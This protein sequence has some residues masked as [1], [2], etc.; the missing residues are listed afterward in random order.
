MRP[1]AFGVEDDDLPPKVMLI[2]VPRQVVAQNPIAILTQL[3]LSA[4]CRGDNV[5]SQSTQFIQSRPT[6]ARVTPSMKRTKRCHL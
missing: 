5:R 2:L 4:G 3:D 1:G 6:A